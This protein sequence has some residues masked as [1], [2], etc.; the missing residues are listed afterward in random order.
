MLHEAYIHCTVCRCAPTLCSGCPGQFVVPVYWRSEYLCVADAFPRL[1][2]STKF[3]AGTC[4]R[5]PGG[6]KQAYM[7]R[8]GPAHSLDSAPMDHEGAQALLGPTVGPS[9]EGAS[10]LE[11]GGGVM[12]PPAS[13]GGDGA[14]WRGGGGVEGTGGGGGGGERSSNKRKDRGARSEATR[15]P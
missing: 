6:T 1:V 10:G 15:A 8:G 13:E 7:T 4:V 3:L 9:A 14:Q 11:T 12:G 5:V 2:G